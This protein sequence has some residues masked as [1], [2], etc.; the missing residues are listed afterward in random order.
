ML[1]QEVSMPVAHLVVVKPG[2]PWDF[3]AEG[4][5]TQVEAIA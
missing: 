5:T 3:E 4:L 2:T 1:V